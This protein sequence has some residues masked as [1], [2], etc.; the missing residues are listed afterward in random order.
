MGI[1]V[2]VCPL[3]EPPAPA[4]HTE[5]LMLST[6]LLSSQMKKAQRG[7]RLVPVLSPICHVPV[8]LSMNTE[9]GCQKQGGVSFFMNHLGCKSLGKE[10]FKC[11]DGLCVR[12]LGFSDELSTPSAPLAS[13]SQQIR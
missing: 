7:Q 10:N 2:S 5:L 3:W 12:R 4:E 1:G 9:P 8:L 6:L 13:L 11:K